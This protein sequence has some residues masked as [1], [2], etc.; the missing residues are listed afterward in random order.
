MNQ[1]LFNI[2]R[3]GNETTIL[4]ESIFS[5]F[6]SFFTFSSLGFAFTTQ[7]MITM[8]KAIAAIKRTEI[9]IEREV[10]QH[11][12]LFKSIGSANNLLVEYEHWLK[13]LTLIGHD[14]PHLD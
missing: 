2:F 1:Y 11:L 6:A 10:P 9:R 8:V 3:W 4:S 14:F 5:I 13:F 12:W 7:Q